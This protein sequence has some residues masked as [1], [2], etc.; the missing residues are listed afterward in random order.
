[1][2]METEWDIVEGN[3]NG[4]LQKECRIF[5]ENNLNKGTEVRMLL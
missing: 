2:K 1:M 4:E 5:F 3:S